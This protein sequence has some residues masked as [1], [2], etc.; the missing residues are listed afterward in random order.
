MILQASGTQG[1]L[2]FVTRCSINTEE[3]KNYINLY[4]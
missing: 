2:L 3:G 4:A 1:G